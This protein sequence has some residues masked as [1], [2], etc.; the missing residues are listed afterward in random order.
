MARRA[1]L[2]IA[3]GVGASTPLLT[4][5]GASPAVDFAGG[6]AAV[7]VAGTFG[8]GTAQLQILAPDN[9]TWV[10]LGSP[11]S[12]TANGIAGFTAPAGKLRINLTGATTPSLAAWVIGIPANNGG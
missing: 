11:T 12:F 3:D 6:N 2:I 7:I 10:P 5:S 4:S 1:Q 8:G 9:T